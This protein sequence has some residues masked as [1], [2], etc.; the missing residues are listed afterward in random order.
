MLSRLAGLMMLV[1]ALWPAAAVAAPG[2]VDSSFGA[3]GTFSPNIADGG[4]VAGDK[5][6]DG[7]LIYANDAAV[8][9]CGRPFQPRMSA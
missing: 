2:D 6:P 3:G 7:S 8:E 9:T 5:A 4:L 1:A